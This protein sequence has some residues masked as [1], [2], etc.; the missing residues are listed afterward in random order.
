MHKYVLEI[1]IH[2]ITDKKE[3][4]IPLPP[5]E[6]IAVTAYQNPL[7]TSLKIDKNPFAKGFRERHD[8]IKEEIRAPL[9]IRSNLMSSQLSPAYFSP[10]PITKSQLVDC[11]VPPQ[12]PPLPPQQ[13]V[14]SS[15]LAPTTPKNLATPPDT[16]LTMASPLEQTQFPLN[17]QWQQQQQTIEELY[18]LPGESFFQ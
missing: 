3:T 17:L 2:N 9:A 11:F 4:I 6:F 5:T 16:P 18:P 10:S 7:L 14:N 1:L 8:D 13:H 15:N 12:H